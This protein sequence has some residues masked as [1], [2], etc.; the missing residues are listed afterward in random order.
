VHPIRF[1]VSV[2]IKLGLDPEVMLNPILFEAFNDLSF[3]VIEFRQSFARSPGNHI[4]FSVE[5]GLVLTKTKAA[6]R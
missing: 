3:A 6:K 5:F 1:A 4:G 2:R